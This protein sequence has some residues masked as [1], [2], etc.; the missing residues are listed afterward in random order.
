[1]TSPREVAVNLIDPGGR[2]GYPARCCSSAGRLMTIE[3][4]PADDAGRSTVLGGE[5]VADRPD[6][7][8]DGLDIDARGDD[9]G[10]R[11]P[12]I[13]GLDAVVGGQLGGAQL[14]TAMPPRH[15][16]ADGGGRRVFGRGEVGSVA[17]GG[18]PTRRGPRKRGE[19]QQAGAA[20]ADHPRGRPRCCHYRGRAGR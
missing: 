12:A 14:D 17:A 20:H 1:M 8:S 18:R 6:P 2:T 19:Q 3:L 7:R 16:K 11:A 4:V 10:C 15:M 5:T 9:A 13:V